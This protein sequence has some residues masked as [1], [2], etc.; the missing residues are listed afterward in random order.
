VRT[1]FPGEFAPELAPESFALE[2]G[3]VLGLRPG[4]FIAACEDMRT[5]SIKNEVALGP[6][7]TGKTAWC[8]AQFKSALRIDLRNAATL[9]EYSSQPERLIASVSANADKKQRSEPPM[10]TSTRCPA[11]CARGPRRSVAEGAPRS[12]QGRT[13]RRAG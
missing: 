1:G 11:T 8:N 9:R 4:S 2:S 7:G 6:R 3:A 5:V 10:C 12:W 13:I